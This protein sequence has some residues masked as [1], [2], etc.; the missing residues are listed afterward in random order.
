[1]T[2]D[3]AEFVAA[4]T[5]RLRKEEPELGHLIAAIRY[6]RTLVARLGLEDGFRAARNHLRVP[7][8]DRLRSRRVL[9]LREAALKSSVFTELWPGGRSFTHFP[10]RVLG[11]GDHAEQRG[12]NRS[13]FL[14][15]LDNVTTRGRS[16][17]VLAEDD[18]IVDFEHDELTRFEDSPELDPGI[19]WA[20]GCRYWTMEPAEFGLTVDE[21]FM[22]SGS[23]TNDF[24]HWL[25]EYLP[26]LAIAIMAKL[27]RIPILVDELIPRTHIQ[28]LELFLPGHEIVTIPHLSPVR[29]RK[30]WCASNPVYRGFYPTN[31]SK[32]WLGMIPDPQNFA[33]TINKLKSLAGE[34]L[35]DPT[36]WDRVYLARK[37]ER[38][39]RLM[40]HGDIEAA[41]AERGFKVLYPEDLSFPEQIRLVHHARHIVAPDGSNALLTYF[42]APGAQ[43]SVLNSQ[44]TYPLVELNGLLAA[45]SVGFTIV[46]GPFHGAMLEEPF[47]TD[48]TIDRARFC[49]FLDEWL[50]AA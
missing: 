3:D 38:K 42:A 8:L 6:K 48:Y 5:R 7:G 23:H 47:W 13:A 12:L 33:V 50:K 40:N 39:K 29:V 44:Q 30:L 31:W 14:A 17:V 27:P 36:G 25:T 35:C 10:P 45:L 41:A 1:M 32:A 22:L 19:L 34:A 2:N 49:S 24:G 46:T 26:K 9:A 21:A 16:A 43:V 4:A 20:N 28:S 11:D 18:A 15:R 37:P